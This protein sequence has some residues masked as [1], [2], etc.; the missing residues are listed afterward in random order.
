MARIVVKNSA[1]TETVFDPKTDAKVWRYCKIAGEPQW[2]AVRSAGKKKIKLA[3]K[4]DDYMIREILTDGCA[5]WYYSSAD[6]AV[7]AH[8]N[9]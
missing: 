3:W 2:Y 5:Y 1:G 6:E 8:L 4:D 7:E 9:S